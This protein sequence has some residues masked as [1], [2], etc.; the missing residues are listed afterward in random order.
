[1]TAES[2]ALV[3]SLVVWLPPLTPLLSPSFGTA[4]GAAAG[5]VDGD[6]LLIESGSV[7]QTIR[8]PST[9]WAVSG[10]GHD[11]VTGC[12][13]GYV[14][15]FT[16]D[17]GREASEE[18][19]ERFKGEGEEEERKRKRGAGTSKEDLAKYEKWEARQPSD[20]GHQSVKVFNKGG[21]A[22]AAQWDDDAKTWVLVGQVTGSSDSGTI[23]GVKY[24]W[25]LPIEHEVAGGGEGGLRKAPCV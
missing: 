21:E 15:S 7:T 16:R 10:R 8:H 3:V 13:D 18:E 22:W 2:E 1:M 12:Q 14:R 20:K 17:K 9:V 24:D 11:V 6:L 4:G 23:D 5:N 25:V 19:M